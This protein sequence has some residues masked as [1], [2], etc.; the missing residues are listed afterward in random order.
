[1][2]HDIALDAHISPMADIESPSKG[3][4]LRVAAGAMIDAFVKIKMAGGTGDVTIAENSHLNSGCVIYSDHG[5]TIGPDVLIAANCTLA[6][7]NYAFDDPSGP[8]RMQGFQ[9]SRGGI[10]VED[11]VWIGANCVLLDGAHIGHGSVVSAGSVVRSRLG[12]LA[13]YA[14]VPMRAIRPRGDLRP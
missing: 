12:P 14:G 9:P 7:T 3:S 6:A 5:V 2:S 10:I 13:I 4:V 11:D 1:M 8:I